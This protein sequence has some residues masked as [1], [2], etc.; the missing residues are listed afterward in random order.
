MML[1]VCDDADGDGDGDPGDAHVR[2]WLVEAAVPMGG[3]PLGDSAH[4]CTHQVTKACGAGRKLA[5]LE[6]HPYLCGATSSVFVTVRKANS[7]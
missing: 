7:S 3:P 4:M 6:M 1:P 2:H 5:T